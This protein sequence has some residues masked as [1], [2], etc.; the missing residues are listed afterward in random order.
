MEHDLPAFLPPPSIS[1]VS[2]T[3]DTVSAADTDLFSTLSSLSSISTFSSQ[4]RRRHHHPSQDF[5]SKTCS[6]RQQESYHEE[7]EFQLQIQQCYRQLEAGVKNGRVEYY[8]HYALFLYHGMTP[9]GQVN[10][11]LA[12]RCF[13]LAVKEQRKIIPLVQSSQRRKQWSEMIAHAQYNIGEMLTSGKGVTRDPIKALDYFHAAARMGHAGAQYE[14]AMSTQDVESRQQW[15]H[16][17]AVQ[18]HARAQALL[19]KIL[20]ENNKEN[21]AIHWLSLAAV[22]HENKE[23]ILQLVH[24]YHH[25][26]P[27]KALALCTRF[28]QS[29]PNDIDVNYHVGIYWFL[30]GDPHALQYTWR[31][32]LVPIRL[33]MGNLMAPLPPLYAWH[34]ASLEDWQQKQV[35]MIK[36]MSITRRLYQW[37][38]LWHWVCLDISWSMVLDVSETWSKH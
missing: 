17:A 33:T 36:H 13:R 10:Y 35:N 31:K 38:I 30:N 3:D 14:I 29:H 6:I 27:D 15:L 26:F 34:T 32:W 5:R 9:S 12:Y 11:P 37:V 23:S 4:R 19:G 8:Y 25:S 1:S 16:K 21:E 18:G 24:L 20:L 7:Q 22:H 28:L 2:T